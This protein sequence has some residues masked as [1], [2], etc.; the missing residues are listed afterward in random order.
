[1]E[2]YCT[3]GHVTDDNMAH[4]H[5]MLYT[6]GYKHKLRISN[7]H[8]FSHINNGCK[9]APQYYVIRKSSVLCI[10]WRVCLHHCHTNNS[11][12]YTAIQDAHVRSRRTNFP[13]FFRRVPK[14]SKNDY[15]LR[16]LSVCPSVR[17]YVTTLFPLDGFSWNL[18]FEDFSK[19]C[20]EYSSFINIWQ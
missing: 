18:V 6:S 14:I 3:A 17:P 4:A 11:D 10:T 5:C 9:N 19:I 2:K 13:I 12:R 7:T 16:H 15:Q 20:R 1:M 8:C